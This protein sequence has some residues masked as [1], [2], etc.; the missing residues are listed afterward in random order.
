[1]NAEERLHQVAVFGG[2]LQWKSQPV[3]ARVWY[4]TNCLSWPS[5]VLVEGCIQVHNSGEELAADIR[6]VL[7][8]G[9]LRASSGPHAEIQIISPFGKSDT[10]M[11]S[12]R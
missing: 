6:G 3:I 2:L 11:G 12:W 5:I 8:G 7:E 10:V 9:V 4:V 1:M